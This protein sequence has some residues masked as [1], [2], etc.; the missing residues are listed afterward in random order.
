MLSCKILLKTVRIILTYLQSANP[1][2]RLQVEM[3]SV[4]EI[5]FSIAD[6]ARDCDES[7][8]RLRGTNLSTVIVSPHTVA[9]QLGTQLREQA[10]HELVCG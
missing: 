6:N 3:L 10:L 9:C 7:Y 4:F 8:I 2:K 1:S 5:K